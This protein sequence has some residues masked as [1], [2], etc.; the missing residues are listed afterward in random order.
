MSHASLLPLLFKGVTNTLSPAGRSNHVG[1]IERG[2]RAERTL[3]V[4]DA[5]K[6]WSVFRWSRNPDDAS[7]AA[8]EERSEAR[9]SSASGGFQRLDLCSASWNTEW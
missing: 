5:R 7:T 2:W 1:G 8:C 4:R 3:R 6:A 9:D